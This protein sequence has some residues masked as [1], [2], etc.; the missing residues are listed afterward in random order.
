MELTAR[1]FTRIKTNKRPD[2]TAELCVPTHRNFI[3]LMRYGH[4]VR[5]LYKYCSISLLVTNI[6]EMI[7]VKYHFKGKNRFSSLLN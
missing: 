4:S 7:R 6:H 1:V 2:L 5:S 3:I